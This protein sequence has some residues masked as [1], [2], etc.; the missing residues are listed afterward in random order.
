MKSNAKFVALVFSAAVVVTLPAYAVVITFDGLTGGTV[1]PN[2]AIR[3][4]SPVVIDGYTFTTLPFL[5][6]RPAE[7]AVW[8]A[9][10]NAN[11]T[12]S[13]YTGSISLFSNSGNPTT[14]RASDGGAFIVSSLSLANIYRP[15]NSVTV[16]FGGSLVGG[17]SVTQTFTTAALDPVLR[18]V[19]LSGFVGLSSLTLSQVGG[20]EAFQFDNVNV[21]AVP[22]PTSALMLGTGLMA[23]LA[24]KRRA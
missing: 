2:G 6:G 9:A 4:A 16:M 24:L 19:T 20:N 13:N 10:S 11:A 15:G 5:D 1:T 17:G 22:E 3:Y 7:F 12:F 18:T 14:M 21:Q 23:L 8:T